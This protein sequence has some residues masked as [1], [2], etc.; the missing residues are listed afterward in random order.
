MRPGGTWGLSLGSTTTSAVGDKDGEKWRIPHY[1][2]LLG[3]MWS[4]TSLRG[5]SQ[6]AMLLGV[7]GKDQSAD[8][9]GSQAN[10]VY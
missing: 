2:R 4:K 8:A 3:E 10:L 7:V 9:I 5:D 6:S 1:I